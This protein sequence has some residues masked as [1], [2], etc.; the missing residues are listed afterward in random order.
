[1]AIKLIV[2]LGN[3]GKDY[4]LHRHNVGF[5]FIDALARLYSG[6]FKKEPK[7]FGELA[8][9][10]IAGTKTY[11][12]KPNTYMNHSGRSIQSVAKFYQIN[13]D[14][15]LVAHDDLDIPPGTIK[16]KLSGGHGGHNGI[17]D[18]IKALSGNDFYRLRIGIGRPDDKSKIVDFVLHPAN[19]SEE[20]HIQDA[21]LDALNVIEQVSQGETAQAMKTLH[22]K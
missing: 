16:I 11:L 8:Q 4:Q 15:I 9:I 14:E 17:K 2:G 5:W 6:S 3:P 13:V 19:K 21:L 12:L 18:T 22:T 20:G 7:F 10:I 1:M